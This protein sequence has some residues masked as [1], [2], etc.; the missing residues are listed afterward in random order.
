M[1][2]SLPLF[3]MYE[4]RKSLRIKSHPSVV[5]DPYRFFASTRLFHYISV[6]CIQCVKIG[7]QIFWITIQIKSK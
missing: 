6:I 2:I 1:Q 5:L 3:D 7:L 4:I